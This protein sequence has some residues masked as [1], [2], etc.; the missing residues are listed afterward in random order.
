M[1]FTT[2]SITIQNK[3]LL[4]SVQY[5]GKEH[6]ISRMILI[7]CSCFKE[8]YYRKQ[9]SFRNLFFFF[10]LSWVCCA[11]AFSSCSEQEL[12]FFCTAWDSHCGGF[13]Y[14]GARSQQLWHT[15]LV[16][17]QHVESSWT[18]DGTHVPCIGRWILIH[19][20]TREVP[21]SFLKQIALFTFM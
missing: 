9:I 1:K 13:C 8:S 21:E 18:R 15:G 2:T 17:P 19:C 20:S 7:D 12:L 5:I 16:A 6:K 14:C 10:W 11:Q 4:L 3:C